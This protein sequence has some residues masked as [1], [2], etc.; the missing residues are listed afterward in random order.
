MK[1]LFKLSGSLAVLV[2]ALAAFAAPAEL[3]QVE[4][5]LSQDAQQYVVGL[6]P[7]PGELVVDQGVAV[8]AGRGEP[9]VNPEGLHL[10]L[11]LQNRVDEVVNQLVLAVAGIPA[12]QVGTPELVIPVDEADRP[13]KF[14]GDMKGDGGLPRS[15]RAGK[16][17][18][19]S[20]FEIGQGT[21]G[22][23]LNIGRGNELRAGLG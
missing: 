12:D 20:G 13:S 3:G 17:D 21:L 6:G 15:G 8:L 10:L 11:G 7:R 19:V 5:L 18:R 4:D 23:L 1:M 22:Q 16:V 2:F 9:I 14:R